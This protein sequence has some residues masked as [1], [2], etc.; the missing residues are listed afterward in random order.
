MCSSLDNFKEICTRNYYSEY[1]VFKL[2]RAYVCC[3]SVQSEYLHTCRFFVL[4]SNL[5][6]FEKYYSMYLNNCS[7]V[8]MKENILLVTDKWNWIRQTLYNFSQLHLTTYL[9][10]R[11]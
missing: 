2:L 5:K 8:L 6:K 10:T 4:T 7:A 11:L 9:V 3:N 1:E